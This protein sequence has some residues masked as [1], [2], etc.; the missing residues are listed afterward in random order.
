VAVSP[1]DERQHGS[2]VEDQRTPAQRD[3]DRI[4]YSSAFRRLAGVTQVVGPVEGHIF[5]NR[6]THTL[7]VAQIARR[8]AEKFVNSPNSDVQARIGALGGIDP[9]VVEAAALVHDL[10]HPPFGHAGEA[11]LNKLVFEKKVT[12]GFEGNPQSFRIVTRLAAHRDQYKGL[13]LTR[14]TL[15]A[16]LKY[17]Y[18]RKVRSVET[19]KF[20]AYDNDADAFTFARV[21][22]TGEIKSV[23]G[24]I[25]DFA[26]GVAYSV[27]DL[28]DFFR[29]GLIPLD[30]LCREKADDFDRFIEG[31]KTE[32]RGVTIT[33]IDA[34]RQTIRNWLSLS[35]SD[36]EARPTFKQAALLRTRTASLIGRFVSNVELRA[37]GTHGTALHQPVEDRVLLRFCQRLVWHYVIDN[38]SLATQQFGQRRVIRA[39]FEVYATAAKKKKRNL[40]PPRYHQQLE[41]ATDDAGAIRL[42]ADIIASFTDNQA[43]LMFGRFSGAASGSV[44]EIL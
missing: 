5:H 12:D 38:P 18:F 25:M 7:E 33:E 24:E 20:G 39:L 11:E 17:P 40:I 4:L 22:C 29:A 14:A 27:H 2:G 6:L 34:Q 28:D 32:P 43:N 36:V 13:N 15:N 42:A 21:G 44:T 19:T 3:R 41:D 23:E 35:Y 1:R 26:D 31:W 30:R 37:G 9:D 16:A 10:G 8:V